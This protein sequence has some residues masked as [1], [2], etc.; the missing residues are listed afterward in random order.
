MISCIVTTYKRDVETLS[1]ALN[2]IVKQTYKNIEIIVINDAPEMKELSLKIK[3]LIDSY[4]MP[5]KYIV[6]EKNMGACAAR[7]TGINLASGEY[8]AFLDDDDEWLPNKLQ[9]QLKV[10]REEK[11]D[12]VYCSYYE[13]NKKGKERRKIEEFARQG[14]HN[15]EIKRLLCY[16]YIGSTSFPLLRLSAVKEVGGFNV[17]LESSQDYELW[18]KIAQ[19]YRIAYCDLPL[20]KYHFSKEAISRSIDKK[21]QGYEYLFSEFAEYYTDKKI[22][23]YRYNVIAICCLMGHSYSLFFYYWIKA[24]MTKP[25][26]K[27]NFMVLNKIIKKIV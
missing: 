27:N 10:M 6:H 19:R 9:E 18:L 1:R 8:I 20:A 24:I 12:L 2:S 23:N 17:Q 13:V 22:L 3:Q 26:S 25:I 7:N 11:A 15:D 5:I 16:N 4:K 21:R 14:V